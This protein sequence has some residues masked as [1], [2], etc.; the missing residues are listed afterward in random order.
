[1]PRIKR[2]KK[3]WSGYTAAQKAER[4]R[5]ARMAGQRGGKARAARMTPEE[6]SAAARHAHDAMHAKRKAKKA[7]VLDYVDDQDKYLSQEEFD[8]L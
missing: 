4:S 8:A 1:M 2:Q 5:L 3:K 6:R 7:W